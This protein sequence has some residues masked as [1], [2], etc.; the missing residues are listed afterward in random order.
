MMGAFCFGTNDC[1]YLYVRQL[2]LRPAL[3]LLFGKQAHDESSSAVKSLE[4][5]I[6]ESTLA[7]IASQCV[8]SALDLMEFLSIRIE[9]KELTCWWYNTSCKWRTPGTPKKCD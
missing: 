2:I 7:E 3:E 4:A 5:K 9:K 8:Q 6:C 1:R